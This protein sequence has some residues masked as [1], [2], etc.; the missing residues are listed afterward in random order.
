MIMPA[1]EYPVIVYVN[2]STGQNQHWILTSTSNVLG[3][4]DGCDIVIPLRQISRQ[5]VRFWRDENDLYFIE[6]LDSR[7]GTWVNGARLEGM[8][9]L[10]DGDEIHLALTARLR[11][12][13]S[14]I[15]APVIQDLP[16]TIPTSSSKARLQIDI[17]GRRVTILDAEVDPALSL[18]QYR[19]LAL[20]YTNMGRVCT[21]EEVVDAVW[22]DTDGAGVSEQAID[23]LVRRLRDRL[24]EIDPDWQYIITVRGHGFRMD[25]GQENS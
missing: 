24:A 23:A 18:P 10:S 16:A 17:E 14:G 11:F 1:N 9:K 22:P 19:L 15:T 6:D 12:I 2:S 7:N 13:G 3:R 8:R 5:H 4:D 20:L 21:R 25:N